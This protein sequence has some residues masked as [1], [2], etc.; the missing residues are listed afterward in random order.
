MGRALMN[1]ISAL[2]KEITERSLSYVKTK[3]KGTVYKP[4]SRF[5][6][7]TE[8]AGVLLLKFSDSRTVR[9]KSFVGV[10]VCV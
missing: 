3:G 1:W 10:C 8:S 7:D 2:I 6:L 5:S 9:K 4:G